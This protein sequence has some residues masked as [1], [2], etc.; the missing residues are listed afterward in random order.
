MNSLMNQ[1]KPDLFGFFFL[2]SYMTAFIQG[3]KCWAITSSLFFDSIILEMLDSH[4]GIVFLADIHPINCT[5]RKR[6]EKRYTL[7]D[8]W[9]NEWMS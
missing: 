1:P 3:F 9:I 4:N 8:V 7:V 5:Y 6:I 2:T